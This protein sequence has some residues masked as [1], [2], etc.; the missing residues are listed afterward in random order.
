MKS[1]SPN[2]PDLKPVKCPR[3]GRFLFSEEIETGR[4]LAPCPNCDA[5][6]ILSWNSGKLQ[7]AIEKKEK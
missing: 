2:I 5:I 3:C 1:S 7:I 6:L 4:A